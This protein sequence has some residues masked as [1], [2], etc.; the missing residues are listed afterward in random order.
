METPFGKL[1]FTQIQKHPERNKILDG[2]KDADYTAYDSWQS[3]KVQLILEET[4]RIKAG[5]QEAI[6]RII[7]QIPRVIPMYESRIASQ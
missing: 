5:L 3:G 2:M 1:S 4:E 7:A 6:G